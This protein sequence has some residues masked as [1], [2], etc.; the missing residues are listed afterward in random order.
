M[1]Y[2]METY[3]PVGDGL[4]FSSMGH[5]LMIINKYLTECRSS[6]SILR[7][8]DFIKVSK[9]DSKSWSLSVKSLILVKT[10]PQYLFT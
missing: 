10:S 3:A 5:L 6:D 7:F 2:R 1:F 4:W 8:I 9:F